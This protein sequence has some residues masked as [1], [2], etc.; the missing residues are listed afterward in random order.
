MAKIIELRAHTGPCTQLVTVRDL[1]G[2]PLP[3]MAVCR[4]WAGAP[5]GPAFPEGCLATR[6]AD[7]FVWGLTKDPEGVV[8]FGMGGGDMPNSSGLWVAHCEAPGDWFGAGGWLPNTVHDTWHVIYQIT[9]AGDEPGP[10]LTD[11]VR[12]SNIW[13][14]LE[15]EA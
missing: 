3:G 15:G 14:E 12:V 10:V 7:Q 4:W 1:E 6:W 9:E 2:Q 13:L 8:G 5:E 11:R